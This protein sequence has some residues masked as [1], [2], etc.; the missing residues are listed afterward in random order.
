MPNSHMNEF[1]RDGPTQPCH[2]SFSNLITRA[3]PTDD[4]EH[5]GEW[6][7]REDHEQIMLY[8]EL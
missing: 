6:E 4:G 2:V 7:D 8:D 5:Y 1:A 3:L